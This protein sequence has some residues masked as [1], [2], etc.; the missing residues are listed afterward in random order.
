MA[1]IVDPSSAS[2]ESSSSEE[3]EDG[4]AGAGAGVP[5]PVRPHN[6]D[7]LV[8]YSEFHSSTFEDIHRINLQ[9]NQY[10][11]AL[12]ALHQRLTAATIT[13]A[14]HDAA[15]AEA[16]DLIVQLR[17]DRDMLKQTEDDTPDDAMADA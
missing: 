5:P 14:Q 10:F 2:D 16:N 11:S 17:I 15:E 9:V 13:Q 7:S 4:T 1:P 12:E 8:D 6:E 3:E